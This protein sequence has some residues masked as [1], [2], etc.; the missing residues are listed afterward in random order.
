MRG[1]L[2]Q[3]QVTVILV[4]LLFL[5]LPGQG[6]PSGEKVE[7]VEILATY[8]HDPRAFTQGLIY[9]EGRLYESTGLYGESSLRR[10]DLKSGRVE[11]IRRLPP[12]FFAEGLAYCRGRLYQLTW[13]N[14]IGFIYRRED[15]QQTGSFTYE[16]E[17]WGLTCDGRQLIMS[18]G[19]NVLRFLDPQSLKVVRTLAVTS[20][21]GG[22]FYLNELEY[23]QGE[24]L[25]NIWMS[26]LIVRISPRTGRVLG[27]L[28]LSPLRAH[29]GK[30][31][32]AEVLN[33]IAFDAK[34]NRLLVTGKL[35]PKLF[36]VRPVGKKGK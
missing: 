29:L 11:M 12:Q 3:Y 24:I 17:G 31:P 28:D 10:V 9:Q 14:G 8:P 18:D 21:R 25:A 19:T 27:W 32:G 33:G 5:P 22:V 6:M 4:L 26:D 16:G 23:V 36:A 34:N 2:R 30:A 20:S 7:G 1:Y 15:F 13:K 35:W